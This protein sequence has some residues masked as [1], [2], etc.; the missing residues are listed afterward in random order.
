MEV[1]AREYSSD[2]LYPPPHYTAHP[3]PPVYVPQAG[4]RQVGQ[5]YGQWERPDEAKWRETRVQRDGGDWSEAA[6]RCATQLAEQEQAEK[7]GGL[8]RGLYS[9]ECMQFTMGRVGPTRGWRA[10]MRERPERKE[11]SP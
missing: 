8:R 2:V 9:K 10:E 3:L 11:R 1:E 7:E 4:S 6:A 5:Q